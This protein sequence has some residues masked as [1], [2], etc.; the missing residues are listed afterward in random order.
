M[1]A[2][3]TILNVDINASA[4]IALSK[5]QNVTAAQII[6]GNGSNVPTAVA[7]TGDI[8]INN[9][10]LTAIASGVI[11]D[12]D[13]SG[14]AA[15]TGSKIA[16]GTTSAVGVLQLTDSAASTSATT[17]AT[18]AAVKT[19]KDAA[20]AAAVTANAALPKAGGT[21]TD[22]LIIDNGKELRLS[23]SDGDGTN[24]TGLKA[25]TQS[26]DIT[27][28]LPAVAPTANQVLK[29][30]ASTPT[31]LTWAA[32]SS[33]DATKM[34]LAG[35]TFTGDVTFTG[36]ASDGLWD[37]S[38]SAFVANLTGNVTGNL[39]GN[40]TGNTSGSAGSC[41]GNAATATALA[42]ARNIGGVSFDGTAA[43]NLPGV[44]A[45][46]TQDTSGTA[47]VATAI[48]VA[49][50]ST[51]TSCNVLFTTAAT[52]DLGAKSGTN[53]TFNSNTGELAAT[54]FS[55][56]GASLTTLNASNISSGTLAAARV[57]TLNQ[58]TT[59]TA[60]LATQFSVTANNSTDE[61]VYPL[62]S[63]GAT[64]AQGAETD[65]GL[66]YNPSSGL[67]TSTGFA[68]ALTGNVT[69]NASGSA[70]TVTG[71]AQSA[72][73]SLGTL[74]GLT[75]LNK[76]NAIANATLILSKG[77]TGAAKLEFDEV[78]SQKAYIELDASEDLIHYAAA[79]VT[80]KFYASGSTALTLDSSQNAT[81]AGTV[82]DSKGDLRRIIKN[83]KTSAYTLVA[84]DA[85]K[86]IPNTTGGWT[87]NN[88]VFSDGDAITLYN[89]SGSD[90]TITRGSGTTMYHAADGDTS[91]TRTLGTRGM[92]TIYVL[93]TGEFIISGAGL[94]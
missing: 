28:T 14:S 67:L 83:A 20:D 27:L 82:S 54:L 13:I 53:L 11:V 55:G 89:N 77:A 56:S 73:T 24:Y 2:N 42:T 72:I 12:G 9:A 85:G 86:C 44:N 50:E 90:Q 60:A 5:L 61:T 37:K 68:G 34:P 74:T 81:F 52:G 3:G 63:D 71:A 48:T 87:I 62:F 38:A 75:V 26:G 8:S 19:A 21:M 1:L 39:T 69:G 79:G 91:T 84:S 22:H 78:D 49:D 10:G 30:D 32:D 59:G 51:D 46:G 76:G 25:Q 88:N 18:P 93:N 33:T 70:A 35:G 23:E 66:T 36:D 29:A 31:T 15:I 47:A 45:S 58:D 64:G 16:T 7:V 17:A 94:S 6:V 80:Q 40:V 41:T 43:I 65:T 57:A 4:A 92:A